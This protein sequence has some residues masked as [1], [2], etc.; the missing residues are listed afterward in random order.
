MGFKFYGKCFLLTLS[1]ITNKIQSSLSQNNQ[2]ME[3]NVSLNVLYM[4]CVYTHKAHTYS[5]VSFYNGVA[6]SN[7]WLQV[8]SS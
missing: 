8:E 6:F 3:T 1:W 2:E 5:R 7:I 4:L